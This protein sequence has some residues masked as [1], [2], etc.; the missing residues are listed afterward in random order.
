M[1]ILLINTPRKPIPNAPKN[2]KPNNLNSLITNKTL[3]EMKK[4]A[5]S[6]SNFLFIKKKDRLGI[7]TFSVL[8]FFHKEIANNGERKMMIK[9]I[10]L[11]KI[12]T[13]YFCQTINSTTISVM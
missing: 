11:T 6:I 3:E 13:P 8:F 4:N 9:G 12:E 10:H 1:S 5:T 2:A 7:V